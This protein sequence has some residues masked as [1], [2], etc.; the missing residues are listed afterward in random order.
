[1]AGV[2][3]GLSNV[4][5]TLM[6]GGLVHMPEMWDTTSAE[7]T[8]Y[9]FK[10]T[11]PAV[12]GNKFSLYRDVYMGI[13][14]IL[15]LAAP[16]AIGK[17]SLGSPFIVSAH[18]PGFVDIKKGIVTRL[19]I[20]KG[21]GEVPYNDENQSLGI[22]IEMQITDV[23][24]LFAL[25]LGKGGV[26]NIVLDDNSMMARYIKM[27]AGSNVYETNYW[28]PRARMRMAAEVSDFSIY[29]TAAF[30]KSLMSHHMPVIGVDMFNRTMHNSSNRYTTQ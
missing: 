17:S 3:L 24:K 26:K 22:E 29:N 2:S 12:Y 7:L 27:L 14:L 1:V 6:G 19:N 11:L 23:D 8:T 10:I 21:I 30:W 4:V 9:S 5:E 25:S 16:R 13:A 15:P 18:L 20:K 28:L